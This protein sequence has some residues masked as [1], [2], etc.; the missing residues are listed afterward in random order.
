MLVKINHYYIYCYALSLLLVFSGSVLFAQSPLSDSAMY[1][2]SLQQAKQR[3]GN[4]MH[5][6]LLLYSGNIYI[7]HSTQGQ[8]AFGSPFFIVDSTALRGSVNYDDNLYNNVL[9]Y[10]DLVD[11]EVI[12]LDT[13]NGIQTVL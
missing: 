7:K 4:T 11:D 12:V 2:Q 3:Y 1:E 13:I 5:S 9:L 6:N 8:K 10:Y